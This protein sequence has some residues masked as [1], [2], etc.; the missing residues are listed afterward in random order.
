MAQVFGYVLKHHMRAYSFQAAAQNAAKKASGLK[1]TDMATD[2]R[3][4]LSIDNC[5][6]SKRWTRPSEW[7]RLIRSM[8]VRFIE[9]SA[10]NECD[11]LYCS[12]EYL[13]DWIREVNEASLAH[14]AQI[15]NV[16]S[17]H[18]T[19]STLGLTHTDPRNREHMLRNWLKPM[20]DIASGLSAGIGFY[21]HA[22]ADAVLQD[23]AAYTEMEH[24]L[25]GS[26]AEMAEYCAEL[27][28]PAS[29][30]EQMYSPHQ[31]PW[32]VKGAEK[33]LKS[34]QAICGRPFYLTIDT[35]HQTGQRRFLKPSCDQ[36]KE[37]A[38]RIR[39]GQGAQS[40]PLWLG[41]SSAYRL[42]DELAAESGAS[43]DERIEQLLQ[44]FDRHPHLFAEYEDG[45]PYIWL[46]T[47][48]SYSPIVHLQQTDGFASAHRPFNAENNGK[49][50]I[51]GAE[52]L[53]AIAR[54][55]GREHADGL[56]PRCAEVYLTLEIFAG[57]SQTNQ[58]VL[59]GM[60]SSVDYWRKL[61]PQD[62]MNLS[63]LISLL[64]N[65]REFE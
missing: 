43:E 41:S 65:R 62:G 47:L 52:V 16:Y 60:R 32:T 54:A 61:V 31:I 10:D 37:F 51:D 33:L 12:K 26:L 13:S 57:T 9:A 11:P 6:A 25:Y 15:A 1:M 42:F 49:G 40:L 27:G 2:P 56:P 53:R 34:V 38:R 63:E 45:D 14:G 59:R 24:E 28:I 7:I 58:A 23:P 39:T 36:I 4:F 64:P 17:G 55:Y 30:V 46:E 19:Y 35:G 3:I 8:G 5:F 20:A 21:C 44:D 29:G 22:F 18:G 48:G 50:I